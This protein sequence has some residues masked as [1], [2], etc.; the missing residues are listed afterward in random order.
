VRNTIGGRQKFGAILVT[1]IFTAVVAPLNNAN[2][3][4]TLK[5]PRT[6][7]TANDSSLSPAT[8]SPQPSATK[9]QPRITSKKKIVFETLITQAE[10]LQRRKDAAQPPRPDTR[11]LARGA[12]IQ[13]DTDLVNVVAGTQSIAGVDI[14][15]TAGQPTRKIPKYTCVKYPNDDP[16]GNAFGDNICVVESGKQGRGNSDTENMKG[17]SWSDPELGNKIAIIFLT[18]RAQT[19]TGLSFSNELAQIQPATRFEFPPEVDA[20]GFWALVDYNSGKWVPSWSGNST[21]RAW[22]IETRTEGPGRDRVPPPGDAGKPR[23]DRNISNLQTGVLEGEI[24]WLSFIQDGIPCGG[25]NAGPEIISP[26]IICGVSNFKTGGVSIS[27]TDT[28]SLG[29]R[30]KIIL[31]GVISNQVSSIDV[32]VGSKTTKVWTKIL[33]PTASVGRIAL[34]LIHDLR[35][36]YNVTAKDATGTLIAND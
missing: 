26:H 9:K 31:L 28:A 7:R 34:I 1:F 12:V 23:W 13:T 17:Y 11:P 29:N 8:S 6:P 35:S 27:Q 18:N 33:P 15:F 2:G 5:K 4:S 20:I 16:S 25:W 32:E 14:P 30:N 22:S 24:W 19:I 10:E 3:L 21:T 36:S